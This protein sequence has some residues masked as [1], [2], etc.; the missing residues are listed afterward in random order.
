MNESNTSE[1]TVGSPETSQIETTERKLSIPLHEDMI[2]SSQPLPSHLRRIRE[3]F[4]F[5]HSC[6][7]RLSMQLESMTQIVE[8]I[9]TA[10]DFV[11]QRDI[12]EQEEVVAALENEIEI[13]SYSRV[14]SISVVQF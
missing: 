1:G 4:Y 9:Q 5:D 3:V 6:S 13:I 8:M 11:R 2:L 10:Q 7:E 14:S 12:D